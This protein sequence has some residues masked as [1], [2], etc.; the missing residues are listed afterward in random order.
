MYFIEECPKAPTVRC[1]QRWAS[2]LLLAGVVT[3]SAPAI[4]QSCPAAHAACDNGGCC[5]SSE[6]CCPTLE[7]GCCSSATPYCCGDGTCAAAPSQCGQPSAGCQGYD[8][9]CGDGCAPAGAD[10]CD[11]E[12]HYCPPESMCGSETTCLSGEASL[13]ATLVEPTRVPVISEARVLSPV[14]DPPNASGRSCALSPAATSRSGTSLPLLLGAA[15]TLRAR[16]R[17]GLAGANKRG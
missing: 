16:R 10:C 12:G 8:V 11:A 9:P 15:W 4:S 1:G 5:L 17:R 3:W 2:L 6:Q 14:A 13:P 7:E